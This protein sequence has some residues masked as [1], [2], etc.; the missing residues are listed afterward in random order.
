MLAL[1]IHDRADEIEIA[2]LAHV[3]FEVDVRH[4]EYLLIVTR[5]D[6]FRGVGGRVNT[7]RV[8]GLER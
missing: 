5:V 3:P 2:R 7:S 4:G 1:Q 8:D 6:F